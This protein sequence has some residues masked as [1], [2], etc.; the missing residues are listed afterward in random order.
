MAR[1][2]RSADHTRS[3]K[4]HTQIQS[5]GSSEI[6]QITLLMASIGQ[7]WIDR[8][9]R[10]DAR[11]AVSEYLK[12]RQDAQPWLFISQSRQTKFHVPGPLT[13]RRSIAKL[14]NLKTGRIET[15]KEWL[16]H[17]STAHTRAYI[18]AEDYREKAFYLKLTLCDPGKPYEL[19][20]VVSAHPDH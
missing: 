3:G 10:E 6:L 5:K 18:D 13:L 9:L 12:T 7:R 2:G 20:L 15:A 19:M 8:S 4:E 14:I 16:G 17:T 1:D 11:E